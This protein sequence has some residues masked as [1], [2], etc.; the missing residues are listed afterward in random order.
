MRFGGDSIALDSAGEIAGGKLAGTVTFR[1][2][3]DGLEAHVKM[4]LAGADAAALVLRC[5]AAAGHRIAESE[6]GGRRDRPERRCARRLCKGSGKIELTDAQLAGLDPRTFDAV[7]R[8]VD[9]GLVIEQ[10]RIA[11][12]VR[13]SISTGR[14]SVGRAESALTVIAG[15]IRLSKPAF[16]SM[17]AALSV[18]GAFDLTDGWSMCGW[19]C[20]ARARWPARARTSSSP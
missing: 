6:S 7:T 16:D 10:G 5:G 12:I 11:D 14:L 3:Q 1:S 4:S 18:A 9:Q 8:A 13:K 15:Q 2:A 19:C 17:D 20:P